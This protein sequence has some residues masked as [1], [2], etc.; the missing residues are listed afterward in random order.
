MSALRT[1]NAFA[2]SFNTAAFAR[3]AIAGVV[4]DTIRAGGVVSEVWY[5]PPMWLRELPG[6]TRMATFI[7]EQPSLSKTSA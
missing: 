5:I 1:R 6:F 4:V 7:I 3:P 2:N